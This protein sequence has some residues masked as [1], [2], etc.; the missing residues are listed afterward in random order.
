[1]MRGF[2]KS[3]KKLRFEFV[4][5]FAVATPLPQPANQPLT[6]RSLG[7]ALPEPV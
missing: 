4:K 5:V 3:C 2:G 1:M 6:S 7:V